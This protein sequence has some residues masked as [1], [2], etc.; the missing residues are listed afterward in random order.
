MQHRAYLSTEGEGGGKTG[1]V[2][3]STGGNEG[4]LE[5]LGSQGQQDQSGNI[6]LTRVTSA[7]SKWKKTMGLRLV[8]PH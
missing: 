1:T 7:L 2:T 8:F 4:D 6:I 5:G 3:E